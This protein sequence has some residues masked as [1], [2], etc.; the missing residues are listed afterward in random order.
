MHTITTAIIE[1][2][3]ATWAANTTSTSTP[4]TVPSTNYPYAGDRPMQYQLQW[5]IRKMNKRI[6]C[7]IGKVAQEDNKFVFY[8]FSL[9]LPRPSSL[10]QLNWLHWFLPFFIFFCSISGSPWSNFHSTNGSTQ[11]YSQCSPPPQGAR[12]WWWWR[13]SEKDGERMGE[14]WEGGKG[15][16]K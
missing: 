13:R 10:G 8:C 15:R 3:T 9:L 1:I 12:H 11:A 4:I 7:T 6:A 2:P 5:L 16:R 14:K